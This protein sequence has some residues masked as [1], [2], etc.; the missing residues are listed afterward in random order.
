[1]L[2]TRPQLQI[3]N[4]KTL[5]YPLS[6]AEKDYYLTLAIMGTQGCSPT[7]PT[8]FAVLEAFGPLAP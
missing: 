7:L 3:I 5:K 2:I 1:M 4:C 6:V 8:G